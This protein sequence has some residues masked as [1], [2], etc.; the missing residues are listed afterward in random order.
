MALFL[1]AGS[2]LRDAEL[3]AGV[4]VM[5]GGVS[6]GCRRMWLIPVLG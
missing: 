3:S 6:G 1:L 4:G 5:E 2:Q